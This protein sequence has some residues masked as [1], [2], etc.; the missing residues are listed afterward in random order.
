MK[1]KLEVAPEVER[2][3]AK[4]S[5]RSKLRCEGSAG[6]AGIHAGRTVRGYWRLWE[7]PQPAEDPS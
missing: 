6:H 2:C 1:I 4:P 7:A 5:E 3:D